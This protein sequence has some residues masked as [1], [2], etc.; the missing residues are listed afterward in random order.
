VISEAITLCGGRN[1]FAD[2]APLAPQISAEAVVAA[3]PEI[4]IAAEPDARE[5]GALDMWKRF[6]TLTAVERKQLVTLDAN[7]I[8]RHGPRLA[9]EV[10]ALCA[11]ID[12][13]RRHQ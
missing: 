8:N 9:D 12:G 6:S 11:A 4:I 1:I 10:A 2:L 5:S 13:A 3:N 7:R